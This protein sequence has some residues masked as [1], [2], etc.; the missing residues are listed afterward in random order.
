LK[1]A[2]EKCQV[3]HKGKPL[4]MATIYIPK[5]TLTARKAWNVVF[6]ALK[7]NNCQI[8]LLYPVKLSFKNQDK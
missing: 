8:R 6:Q 4:K 2:R 5:E 1:A 3:T 7:V